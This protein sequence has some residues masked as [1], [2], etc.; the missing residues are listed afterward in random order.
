VWSCRGLLTPLTWA[1]CS[2]GIRHIWHGLVAVLS[3]VLRGLDVPAVSITPGMVSSRSSHMPCVGSFF[4]RYWSRLAW[5][6]RSLLK[7]LAWAR[8][9]RGIRH[10]WCGLVAIFSHALHGFVVLIGG[11]GHSTG[12]Q[13]ERDRSVERDNRLCGEESPD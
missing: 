9:S 1:R 13:A 11:G 6:R 7:C 3:H 5:F 12:S 4:S 8:C 10:A 2:R